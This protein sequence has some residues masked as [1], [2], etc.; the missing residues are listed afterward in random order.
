MFQT[1]TVIAAVAAVGMFAGV[2]FASAPVVA[3][4]A[5]PTTEARVIASGE[6]WLCEGDTCQARM[7][8]KVTARVCMELAREVGQITAFGDLGEA[9]LAR[10]N[11]R[12]AATAT[13]AVA[14]R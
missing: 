2:S 3:K 6:V 7:S 4:L 5:A 1:K 12:A 14:T 11:T 10:C 8:K 13:T 9:E